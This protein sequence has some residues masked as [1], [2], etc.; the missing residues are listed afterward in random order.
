MMA[1]SCG[2][3]DIVKELLDTSRA[4]CAQADANDSETLIMAINYGRLD[5]V[6]ELLDTSRANCAA[7][8]ANNSESLI[9]AIRKGRLDIVKEL[10]HTSR[11]NCASADANN[12][13]SL[14]T[15]IRGG[16]LE[17]VKELLDTSRVNCASANANNSKSLMIAISAGRL[18]NVE[19]LWDMAEVARASADADYSQ[20]LTSAEQMAIVKELLDTSR[21]NHA[22]ADARESKALK[23]DAK[24]GYTDI[25]REL[26]WQKQ[27]AADPSTAAGRE[28]L[29]EA[30]DN[31]NLEACRLL[32]G[33][34]GLPPIELVD[35]ALFK[36]AAVSYNH[37]ILALLKEQ[38]ARV[39]WVLFGPSRYGSSLWNFAG[40][41]MPAFV[42]WG[43][44]MI[45]GDMPSLGRGIF[46]LIFVYLAVGLVNFLV[47]NILVAT[48][49]WRAKTAWR[50]AR[51]INEEYRAAWYKA[52]ET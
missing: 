15:A 39:D 30:V 21:P 36:R 31:G 44:A 29:R 1:I 37:K 45:R 49:P 51:A 26:L 16:C 19:E 5:I 17:I 4:N 52:Q 46:L 8:N 11:V 42:L 2:R 50:K 12:S 7:A 13:E 27:H 10:L 23:T 33:Y 25:L 18:N 32:L 28:A 14:L 40:L 6:K 24:K 34:P 47:Y 38:C 48:R 43:E 9:M 20:P 35:K 22:R 3:L 41:C